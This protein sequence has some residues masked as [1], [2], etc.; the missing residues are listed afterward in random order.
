MH[1]TRWVMSCLPRLFIEESRTA[2]CPPFCLTA[3]EH[4]LI[5]WSVRSLYHTGFFKTFYM[6]NGETEKNCFHGNTSCLILLKKLTSSYSCRG[7]ECKKSTGIKVKETEKKCC[8]GN[9][10]C[11]VCRKTNPPQSVQGH[12][13]QRTHKIFVSPRNGKKCCHGNTCY[14]VLP[15]N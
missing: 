4:C 15:K 2:I 6:H 12:G 8:H 3:N 14:Q 9:T 11:Q 5:L 1:C 7:L 13:K 10:C